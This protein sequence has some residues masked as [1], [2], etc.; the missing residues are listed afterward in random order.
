MTTRNII[1]LTD[2]EPDDR[3]ALEL[4]LA[5]FAKRIL[6]IGTTLFHTGRKK[7][8]VERAVQ[9]Y[10]IPVYAGT[11]GQSTDPEPKRGGWSK[12]KINSTMAGMTYTHEGEGI[13]S[14]E[15]LLKFKEMPSSSEE[16]SIHLKEALEVADE[17][18]LEIVL[19]V[20][21]TDLMKVLTPNPHLNSKIKHIHVMGGWSETKENNVIL[22]RTTYNWDIDLP[23][24]QQLMDLRDVSMT[25][26]SSH[27]I[28]YQFGGTV[29]ARNFPTLISAIEKQTSH[30][31]SLQ[32]TAKAT[33]SWNTHVLEKIPALEPVIRPYLDTQFTPADPVVVVGMVDPKF[34]G[35]RTPI[36]VS[37]DLAKTTEKGCPVTVTND[38]TS[39]IE[40]AE[41]LNL[42]IFERVM[43]SM[44]DKKPE[45]TSVKM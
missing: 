23:A 17:K 20:A 37:L 7:A 42:L 18:S 26:Y 2:F 31:P 22:R 27:V 32:D 41:D 5:Y 15:E 39:L 45:S 33:R 25:L 10:D 3:R 28:K 38:P 30:S 21:P 40:L 13:L 36:R 11:G 19:L 14:E 24:S 44:F 1:V 12:V 34:V 8:L 35:K 43:M 29:N 6:L 4:L 16:L 9:G